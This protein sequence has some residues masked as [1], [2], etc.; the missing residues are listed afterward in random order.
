MPDLST[1]LAQWKSEEGLRGPIPGGLLARLEASHKSREERIRESRTMTEEAKR[2]EITESRRQFRSDW[3]EMRGQVL[4]QMDADIETAR[5][6]ANPP[7]S[8]A[9]LERMGLLAN[10]Y[11]SKWQRA[12]GNMSGDAERFA[13]EGDAAGL[14]L[15]REHSGLLAPGARTTVLETVGKAEESLMSDAQRQAANQLRSL[16]GDRSRFELGTGLR[17]NFIRAK[18]APIVPP[19]ADPVS[20][21]YPRPQR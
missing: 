6:T 9:E 11:M 16:E 12:P 1:K 10:V 20:P 7:A 3:R 8:N 21:A 2:L 13:I 17:E 5:R 14:R 18:T 15:I 19:P 4:E